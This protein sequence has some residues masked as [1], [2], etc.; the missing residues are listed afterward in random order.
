MKKTGPIE[1]LGLW[2]SPVGDRAEAAQILTDADRILDL[3][4]TRTIRLTP[5][6]CSA[7]KSGGS[8][9]AKIAEDLSCQLFDAFEGIEL[10][11][12]QGPV[13][14][15]EQGETLMEAG[16]GTLLA[17]AFGVP[18]VWDLLSEDFALNGASV[19]AGQAEWSAALIRRHEFRGTAVHMSLDAR[20][21]VFWIRD[22]KIICATEAG[23]GA[24][25]LST[26]AGR[27]QITDG[28]PE[29]LLSDRFYSKMGPRTANSGLLDRAERALRAVPEADR[30]T[31][32]VAIIV[33][34]VLQTLHNGPF[35]PQRVFVSGP[36]ST[37]SELVGMLAE[38][39]GMPLENFEMDAMQAGGTAFVAARIV[40][41]RTVSG[42]D[43]T[44]VPTTMAAGTI[45]RPSGM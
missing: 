3:G 25:L 17:E 4:S 27:G 44:G 14:S 20:S 12:F 40:R 29:K 23:P 21:Q 28:T 22:G 8:R 1:V 37:N 16:S 10:V 35:Q 13:L 6:E 2:I 45:S 31:T 24:G 32:A 18:V 36:M 34:G 7:V 43:V 15:F 19:L 30:Y 33:A 39:V 41:G 26:F 42:P 9:S 5:Q 11:G 38:G